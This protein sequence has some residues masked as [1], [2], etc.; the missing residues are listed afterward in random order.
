VLLHVPPVV[1]SA[2]ASVPVAQTIVPPVIA[3][4]VGLTVTTAVEGP[5]P[6]GME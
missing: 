3:A 2:K 6:V 5:Q 1:V 4:G